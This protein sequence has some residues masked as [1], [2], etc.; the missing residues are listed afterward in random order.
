MQWFCEAALARYAEARAGGR[1]FDR[2]ADDDARQHFAL[3]ILHGDERAD[4]A[5]AV[6]ERDAE[7]LH[8]DLEAQRPAA[9]EGEGD[10][11]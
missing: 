11:A 3:G 7:R 8:L 5:G 6:V 9:R 10:D 4:A 1:P 2:V